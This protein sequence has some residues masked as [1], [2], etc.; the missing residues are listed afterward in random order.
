M[1][2]YSIQSRHDGISLQPSSIGLLLVLCG[3]GGCAGQ[4]TEQSF[5]S[6]ARVFHASTMDHGDFKVTTVID[7]DNAEVLVLTL[8]V[9]RVTLAFADGSEPQRVEFPESLERLPDDATM[10]RMA[11]VVAD[12]LD[13][14]TPGKEDTPGC[15]FFPDV[16][17]SLGCCAEHDRCYRDNG[18]RGRSWL[19]F[20]HTDACDVCNQEV[21]WCVTR[22]CTGDSEPAMDNRCYDARCGAY[23]DCG[24]ASCDCESPCDAQ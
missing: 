19:P 10:N 23:F 1:L 6:G 13:K 2:N 12:S 5:G 9:T 15:N 18:C 20:F 16:E 7:Q 4:A 17:C 8:D 14:E 3:L 22:T 24:E 11:V 21:L